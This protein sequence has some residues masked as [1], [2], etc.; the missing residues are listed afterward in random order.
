MQLLL[1]FIIA[2]FVIKY[3]IMFLSDK[4][5][6]HVTMELVKILLLMGLI[7]IIGKGVLWLLQS[8]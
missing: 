8:I 6:L 2:F 5:N 1:I 3:S 4:E 7:V